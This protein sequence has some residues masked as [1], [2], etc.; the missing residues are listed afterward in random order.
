LGQAAAR[1]S[2]V[3]KNIPSD[4]AFPEQTTSQIWRI[5]DI[6]QRIGRVA[7]LTFGTT[8]WR[9]LLGQHP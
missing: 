8:E 3:G 1:T 7:R 9:T 5:A 4:V 2:F 6:L